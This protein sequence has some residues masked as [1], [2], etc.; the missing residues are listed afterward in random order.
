MFETSL[1]LGALED[2]STR[3]GIAMRRFKDSHIRAPRFIRAVADV[4]HEDARALGEVKRPM[5]V[6]IAGQH[7]LPG[8]S[9]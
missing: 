2:P 3:D 9:L 1:M 4:T 5:N 7:R 6:R 8:D